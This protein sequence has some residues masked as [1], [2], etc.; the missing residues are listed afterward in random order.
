MT[1][2]RVRRTIV[3][4]S[5]LTAGTACAHSSRAIRAGEAPRTS[6]PTPA[7]A[8]TIPYALYTHCGIDEA[9]IGASFYEAVDPPGGHAANPPPG[10]GNPFQQGFMTYPVNGGAVFTDRVGHRV[11]FRLRPGATT[12]KRICS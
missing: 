6:S 12:F 10:W 1:G 5:L 2:G 11:L 9:R 7:A 8:T 3:V 4:L